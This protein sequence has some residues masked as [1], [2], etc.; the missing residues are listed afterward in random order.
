MKC[1]VKWI[2]GTHGYDAVLLDSRGRS[3]NAI[4]YGLPESPTAAQK[5]EAHLRLCRPVRSK[6]GRW[7][8]GALKEEI[9]DT[10][11]PGNFEMFRSTKAPTERSH[12]KWY[13]YSIGPFRTRAGAAVMVKYG[14][15]NPHLQDVAAAEKM[16]K[17][18]GPGSY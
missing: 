16:A 11:H 14:S 8:V 6:I 17:R 10:G 4:N 5:S 9:E 15:G 3:I 13:R 7:Y 2:H 1:I 12:G 18:G